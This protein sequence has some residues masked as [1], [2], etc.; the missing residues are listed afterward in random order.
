M[1]ILRGVIAIN[2]VGPLVQR[3]SELSAQHV[4]PLDSG[5]SQARLAI[6]LRISDIL[7]EAAG[8]TFTSPREI[9]I[10]LHTITPTSAG[11]VGADGAR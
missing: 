7:P 3:Q 11:R 8:S 10:L 9:G 5:G 6:P 1:S 4:H 2:S